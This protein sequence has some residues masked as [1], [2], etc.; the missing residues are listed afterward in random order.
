MKPHVGQTLASTVDTTTVIVVRWPEGSDLDI[1]CGGAAMID[2]KATEPVA[3]D[4]DPSQSAGTQLGKRYASDELGVELL[5]TKAGQ[6][7]LAVEGTA[8]PLKSAKPLPASD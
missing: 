6:G 2:P 3:T 4:L 7:T 1:T 8:L 5:C